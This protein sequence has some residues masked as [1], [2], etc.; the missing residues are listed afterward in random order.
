MAQGEHPYCRCLFYT[1]NALARATTRLAEETFRPTGLA[2]SAAY[3]LLA[4]LREPGTSPGHVAEV[5][6]LDRSTVTRLVEGLEKKGLVSR[7]AAGRAVEV[8]PTAAALQLRGSLRRCGRA[9]YRRFRSELGPRAGR[10]A[11]EVF[12]AALAMERTRAAR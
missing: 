10:L 3:V 4:V 8:S 12:A 2:P 6:M 1:S 7:K 5:M 11:D 9:V